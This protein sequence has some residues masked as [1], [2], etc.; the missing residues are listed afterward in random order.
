MSRGSICQRALPS[1]FCLSVNPSLP[2]NT[3]GTDM[4][5]QPLFEYGTFQKQAGKQQGRVRKE[6]L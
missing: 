2:L 1:T 3:E 6:L 4:E 5:E